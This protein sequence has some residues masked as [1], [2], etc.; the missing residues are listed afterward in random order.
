[1]SVLMNVRVPEELKDDFH[2]IC[3][4]NHTYMTTEIIRFIKRFVNDEIENPPKLNQP[5]TT[6]TNPTLNLWGE[7]VQRPDTASWE[8]SY[9]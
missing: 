7:V 1:M 4:D 5:K 8:S 9:D 6:N 3:R 2:M